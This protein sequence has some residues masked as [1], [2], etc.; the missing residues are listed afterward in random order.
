MKSPGRSGEEFKAVRAFDF[1]EVLGA[2]VESGQSDAV[3]SGGGG[4]GGGFGER[5]GIRAVAHRG[6]GGVAGFPGDGGGDIGDGVDVQV[7]EGGRN[8]SRCTGEEEVVD[9]VSVGGVV[10]E[11]I[12]DQLGRGDRVFE[13]V[14][15]RLRRNR[16][17]SGAIVEE[18]FARG[19]IVGL[20][21][22]KNADHNGFVPII[23]RTNG[24]E[25]VEADGRAI[26]GREIDGVENEVTVSG[27]AEVHL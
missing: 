25:K 1:E 12:D 5:A 14:G 15:E 26:I 21:I 24:V 16:A 8:G 11:D 13:L 9:G 20:S 18:D 23:G 27:V 19:A 17:G 10:G 7:G 22:E 4:V 6:I 2:A 3:G